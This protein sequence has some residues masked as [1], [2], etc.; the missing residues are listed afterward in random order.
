[1]DFLFYV[2]LCAAKEGRPVSG[3]ILLAP[4][5]NGVDLYN[6][7]LP[8]FYGPLELLVTQKLPS[9]EYAPKVT[10]K[11]LIIASQSDELVS[12][13]SSE[14]LLEQFAGPVEFMSLNN[15]S[16]DGVRSAIGVPETIQS[17]L[18]DVTK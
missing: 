17:Y 1:M 7:M 12:Y 3:L 11:P 16:H 8:I 2:R 10:C 9:E 15:V 4:Y 5:A 13:A 18:E 6:G 14:H